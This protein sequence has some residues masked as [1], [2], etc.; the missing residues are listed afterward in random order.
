MRCNR[1]INVLM[2]L[3]TSLLDGENI[4]ISSGFSIDSPNLTRQVWTLT[5]DEIFHVR[6][7]K[8]IGFFRLRKN[9]NTLEIEYSCFE[10]DSGKEI[11]SGN[12]PIEEKKDARSFIALPKIGKLEWSKGSSDTI[13]LYVNRKSFVV[14]LFPYEKDKKF[15]EIRKEPEG[16]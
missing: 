12:F 11:S 8:G 16:F 7:D 10:T 2:V 4:E 5:T 3:M 15:P 9:D 1:L 6:R 13:Y 14:G